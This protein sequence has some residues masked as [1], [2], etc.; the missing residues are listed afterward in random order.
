MKIRTITLI[1]ILTLVYSMLFS[2]QKFYEK[3][4]PMRE[5]RQMYGSVVLG[6]YVYI[7]GG[8]SSRGYINDVDK[9][10]IYSNG[11]IS[12]WS[13]TTSMPQKRSYINNSTIALNDI[14]YVVGGLE[15]TAGV[16][17][18][19][20]LWTR[21][22]ANGDLGLWQESVAYPGDGV[23]CAPA[24][25]TRGHIH[26]LGGLCMDER[27]SNEVW[28]AIV[29][30]DGSI[31][32]WEKGQNLPFPLWFHCA[33]VA[34]GYVWIWGGA[35]N[36]EKTLVNGQVFA[37]PILAS[38]KLGPWQLTS[39][40]LPQPFYSA[41]STVTE[42][43][44]LSFC[45][46]YQGE[47]VSNDIWFATVGIQGLSKWSKLENDIPSKLYIGLATDYRRGFVYIPGGRISKEN[48][49]LDTN[50]YY[51]KLARSKSEGDDKV[52]TDS[53]GQ[54]T[55]G[56]GFLQGKF[57]SFEQARQMLSSRPRA[58]V[59]YFHSPGSRKC[60]EQNG[61]LNSFNSSPYIDSV[62]FCEIDMSQY[63]QLA[64]QNGIFRSPHWL[65]FNQDQ[66]LRYSQYGVLTH[67]QLE[68]EVSKITRY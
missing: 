47:I 14:V 1:L 32:G 7:L 48:R 43:Y 42:N 65:I 17:Y 38:G 35:K 36:R 8:N 52:Q 63:P 56:I 67:E 66:K 20:I 49:N 39:S 68:E 23:H 26:S 29:A 13:P 62:I 12:P 50:V 59:I 51:L 34:G 27:V 54:Q 37:A 41:S 10:V 3:T 44:L 57:N 4:T 61:I 15:G 9:A 60:S 22:N 45:P 5:G 46:R 31:A 40:V 64:Q 2:S 21:P 30:P 58:L 11:Q 33:E 28:T 16:C 25:A 55:S 53:P 19:T 24:V 18:N 6:N